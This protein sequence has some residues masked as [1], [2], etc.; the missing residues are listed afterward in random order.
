MFIGRNWDS[1]GHR[2]AGLEFCRHTRSLDDHEV[3][4]S[5]DMPPE[6]AD[7]FP[8]AKQRKA[9]WNG[10]GKVESTTPPGRPRLAHCSTS[11]I[12]AY[13]PLFNYPN[14][15]CLHP[16]RP[17]FSNLVLIMLASGHKT[18]VSA[19]NG[20]ISGNCLQV[21]MNGF[22]PRLNCPLVQPRSYRVTP[23]DLNADEG[24]WRK[25]AEDAFRLVSSRNMARHCPGWLG[26]SGSLQRCVSTGDR[27][28]H[29]SNR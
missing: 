19:F 24:G 28:A 20:S 27:C 17:M 15:N 13:D 26:L 1:A 2:F 18:D 7:A 11:G 23:S 10:L 12:S 22:R 21:P 4:E 3:V 25:A 6:D 29:F 14:L 9:F 8:A 16:F 5:G